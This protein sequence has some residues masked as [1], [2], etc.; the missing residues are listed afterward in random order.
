M[1]SPVDEHVPELGSADGDP[2]AP[3]HYR[4]R[5]EPGSNLGRVVASAERDAVNAVATIEPRRRDEVDIVFAPVVPSTFQ[6]LVRCR[7]PA[8]DEFLAR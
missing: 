6:T 8:I 3:A 2:D 4:G 1:R 5:R 7:T